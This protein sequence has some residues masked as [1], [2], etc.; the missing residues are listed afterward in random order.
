M[1]RRDKQRHQLFLP[2]SLSE[3]LEAMALKTGTPRSAILAAALRS[4]LDNEGAGEFER[5]F[6]ARLD[7]LSRQL[8]RIERDG[9]IGLESLALFIRYM[10]TVNAPLAE[11]DE[12]ARAIGRDRFAAFIAKVSRRLSAGKRTLDP[13]QGE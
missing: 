8:E 2:T 12:M 9:H 6:Q 7:R 11:E 4:Y 5:A 10:L 13:E 1:A 3:R